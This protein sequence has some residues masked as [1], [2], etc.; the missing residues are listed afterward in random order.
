VTWLRAS[1]EHEDVPVQL[2]GEPAGRLP[3]EFGMSERE[4]VLAC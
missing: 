2:D 4:L 1:S 3:M